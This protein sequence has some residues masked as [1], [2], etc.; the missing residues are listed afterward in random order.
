MRYDT[1]QLKKMGQVSNI[2][3]LIDVSAML[4]LPAIAQ[5]FVSL[6]VAPDIV[7]T[8]GLY[9]IVKLL[10]LWHECINRKGLD[11]LTFMVLTMT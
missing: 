6:Y 2:L 8:K 9:K 3:I 5:L 4:M 10:F 1:S 7:Y 11:V